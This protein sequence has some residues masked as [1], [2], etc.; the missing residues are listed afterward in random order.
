M[1]EGDFEKFLNREPLTEEL[2][3]LQRGEEVEV[4]YAAPQ[5]SIPDMRALDDDDR[6]HLRRLQ[7][8]SGW[9]VLL[10]LINRDIAAHKNEAEKISEDDPLGKKDQVAQAWA[11]VGMMKR[12]RDRMLAI[13]QAE[14]ETLRASE[15]AK[16]KERGQT[17]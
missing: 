6:E 5:F 13:V 15:A 11:Y 8:E 16:K 3:A 14:I 17:Q 4:P 10:R 2:A 1:A 9:S 12:G 7:L